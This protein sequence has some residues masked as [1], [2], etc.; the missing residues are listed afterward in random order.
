MVT[1]VVDC[2][3]STEDEMRNIRPHEQSL[4][5]DADTSPDFDKTDMK[6]LV[7]EDIAWMVN[8]TPPDVFPHGGYT[9]A[10][11]PNE[12]TTVIKRLLAKL[13]PYLDT[14]Y[15]QF[16]ECYQHSPHADGCLWAGLADRFNMPDVKNST[17]YDR[18]DLPIAHNPL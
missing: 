5:A 17:I 1:T 14:G 4:F 11:S 12:A 6:S 10:M 2:R 13:D 16:C 18:G 15:C 7:L 8:P 3:E 9:K